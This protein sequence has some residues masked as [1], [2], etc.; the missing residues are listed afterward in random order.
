MTFTALS[1][2]IPDPH[3]GMVGSRTKGEDVKVQRLV[4]PKLRPP[5]KKSSRV[6]TA[7][8]LKYP[9]A[10]MLTRKVVGL[11]MHGIPS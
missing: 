4:F 2:E 7:R 8:L 9:S 3:A 5:R 11:R 10:V 6:F 1:P